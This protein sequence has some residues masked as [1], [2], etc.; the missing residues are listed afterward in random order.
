MIERISPRTSA[1]L[2]AAGSAALLLAALGFQF[3]GGLAPC[4][5][6]IWQRWPHVAAVAAG[7]LIFALPALL[8]PLALL[9]ALAMA[10]NAGIAFYHSGIERGWWEGPSTCSAPNEIGSLSTEQLMAQIMQAP[11][12]RCDE[13]PW[14]LFGL[15]M[16]NWNGIASLALALLWL[17]AARGRAHPAGH[18]A[19]PAQGAS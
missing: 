2:A 4:P 8:R 12:V 17:A 15:S 10:V 13:I 11:L 18:Q 9:G 14:S 19:P 5:L 7:V 6:C 3:L 1:L 16:A